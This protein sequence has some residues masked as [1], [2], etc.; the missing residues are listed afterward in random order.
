MNNY[1]SSDSSVGYLTVMVSTARGAIPLED[2]IVNVRGGDPQSSDIIY[3]MLSDRDGKTPKVILATPPLSYSEAPSD[4]T[5]YSVYNVDV[6]KE[7]YVPLFFHNVPIFPSV[8][9]I[10]PAIMVPDSSAL[11]YGAEENI[12][13]PKK[14]GE[15]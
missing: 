13:T 2:A 4:N 15:D 14:N 3:S 12:N 7:G 10:Q 9:S 1:K 6:F 5:A 8:H 11:A